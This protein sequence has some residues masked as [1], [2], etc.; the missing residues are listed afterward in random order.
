MTAPV[1]YQTYA[2]Y[3][4]RMNEA[5]YA[6]AAMLSNAERK[7]DQGA[8]FKSVHGTLNH[9]F[10]GDHAWMGRFTGRDY[11]LAPIGTDLF[12]DFDEMRDAR[13]RLDAEIIEWTDALTA[14]WLA[15]EV[16]WT[17]SL[18]GT[19][20][21]QAR[22]LMVLHMFNHQTHHRGQLTTLLSQMGHD[23]GVTD[24]TRVL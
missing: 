16:D 20:R 12:D 21:R 22:W 23:V 4:R 3:N 14:D 5:V 13:G 15:E 24:L 2:R 1:V 9:L 10:F 17:S 8:F 11:P 6:V 19:T 18:D 7:R